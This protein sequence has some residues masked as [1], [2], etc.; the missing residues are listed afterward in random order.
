MLG[1]AVS[2]AIEVSTR[3]SPKEFGSIVP[4]TG[5]WA[6]D[7]RQL[8]KP[9][10]V[11]LVLINWNYAAYVGEAIRSIE[12]QDYPN[13]EILVVDNGS[14]DASRSVIADCVGDNGR[15][16]IIHLEKN[17]GSLGPSSTSSAKSREIF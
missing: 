1:R 5:V 12:N 9:P 11:S 7:S 2:E 4:T 8:F 6:A 13:L 16:R 15:A 17:L 10:L 14:T 3:G